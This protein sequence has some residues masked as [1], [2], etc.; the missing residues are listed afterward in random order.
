MLRRAARTSHTK[1]YRRWRLR[2][3]LRERRRRPRER[4]RLRLLQRHRTSAQVSQSA[5][6]TQQGRYKRTCGGD[7]ESENGGC[8][9]TNATISMGED[10]WETTW[11]KG[12]LGE[13][14]GGTCTL[15]TLQR[16]WLVLPCSNAVEG[17]EVGEEGGR[18][19]FTE[20]CP[21]DASHP[22][23]YGVPEMVQM[24]KES[25]TSA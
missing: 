12:V 22:E 24:R 10:T 14:R 17:C 2:L 21:C 20:N 25:R 7:A 19:D 9:D 6:G 11:N 8:H 15:A 3:R 18:E 23:S 4:L 16:A 5:A 13:S 1:T